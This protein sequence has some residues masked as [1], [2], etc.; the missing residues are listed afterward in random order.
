MAQNTVKALVL[1]AFDSA[2]LTQDYQLMN[3]GGFAE[4]PFMIFIT[5]DSDE[6]ITISFNGVDD[7]EY[8]K[9]GE[10]KPIP[11]QSNSQPNAN[12]ALWSKYTLVFVRGLA[13]TGTIALS[14]YYV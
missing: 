8:V 2:S 5:N 3:G 11:A 13:G 10:T 7:N 6:A 1:S 12:V 9:A 4:S 14:G